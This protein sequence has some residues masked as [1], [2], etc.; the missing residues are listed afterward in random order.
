[1]PFSTRAASLSAWFGSAFRPAAHLVLLAYQG[2]QA[3]SATP[4]RST[5]QSPS[6][7]TGFRNCWRE[8]CLR[9]GERVPHPDRDTG[10]R[11]EDGFSAPFWSAPKGLNVSSPSSSMSTRNETRTTGTF[12]R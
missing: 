11:A 12:G 5:R 1:M 7:E 9:D 8:D 4:A 3:Q 2:R 6:S 10:R